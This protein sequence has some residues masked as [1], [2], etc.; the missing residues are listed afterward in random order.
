MLTVPK[1]GERYFAEVQV[2]LFRIWPKNWI[3][4]REDG[5]L[6][7]SLG[8]Q[9]YG[10][11]VHP[12][13]MTTFARLSPISNSHP[14]DFLT[15][16]TYFRNMSH[17]PEPQNQLSQ[18]ALLDKMLILDWSDGILKTRFTSASGKSLSRPPRRTTES[19]VVGS[20]QRRAKPIAALLTWRED[21]RWA[22]EEY[23]EIFWR[24]LVLTVLSVAALT[25]ASAGSSRSP[26]SW[27]WWLELCS[28]FEQEVMV[29][30]GANDYKRSTHQAEDGEE[31]VGGPGSDKL[32]AS[33]TQLRH[34]HRNC[35]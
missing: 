25:T 3:G 7:G 16:P 21:M 1:W 32:P 28:T 22:F 5:R 12:L 23:L 13:H 20:R 2:H 24:H 18:P 29:C 10:C 9:T 6:G 14:L 15:P 34:V 30:A 17:A 33:R 4:W 35:H 31:E 26:W 19:A 27:S 11:W 8:W